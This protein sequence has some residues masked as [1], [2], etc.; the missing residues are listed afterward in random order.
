MKY[1]LLLLAMVAIIASCKK[2]SRPY[3]DQPSACA[4]LQRV[5][6]NDPPEPYARAAI[7]GCV[8]YLV[9]CKKPRPAPVCEVHDGS[10]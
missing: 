8:Q 3:T 4:E 6:R 10:R 9:L 5:C 2:R 7:L 1:L